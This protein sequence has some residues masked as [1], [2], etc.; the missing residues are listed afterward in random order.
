MREYQLYIKYEK[1]WQH[2][3]LLGFTL[4]VDV[5]FITETQTE[6]KL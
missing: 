6:E 1:L 3:F 5:F 4:Q 2:V